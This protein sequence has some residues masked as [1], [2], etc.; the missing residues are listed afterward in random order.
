MLLIAQFCATLKLNEMLYWH[1]FLLFLNTDLITKESV[2]VIDNETSLIPLLP[3]HNAHAER[4]KCLCSI[5]LSNN[6]N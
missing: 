1:S 6:S 5:S 4:K 3:V 2:I